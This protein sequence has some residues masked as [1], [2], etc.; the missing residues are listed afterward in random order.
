M[1]HLL[2]CLCIVLGVIVAGNAAAIS[3]SPPRV[4][5]QDIPKD[6]SV[7]RSVQLAGIAPGSNVQ[8]SKTGNGAEWV[9]LGFGESFTFPDATEVSFP[10]IITVPEKAPNGEY[11]ARIH[12]VADAPQEAK[13]PNSAAVSSGVFVDVL[14]TVSGNEVKQYSIT[15]VHIPKI[16]AGS[17]LP[18]IISIQNHGNVLAKPVKVDL[19]IKDKKKEQVLFSESTSTLDPVEPFFTGESVATFNI[20]LPAELYFADVHVHKDSAII[21]EENIPFE[22]LIP[23]SLASAGE[24]VSLDVHGNVT[25]IA[26]IEA[27]FRNTGDVGFYATLEG[28]LYREGS[29]VDTFTSDQVFFEEKTLNNFVFFYDVPQEGSYTVNAHAAF[30]NKKSNT[31][32]TTFQ[33]GSQQKTLPDTTLILTAVIMVLVVY[34]LFIRFRKK[35]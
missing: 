23:G 3:V 24:L 22:V 33:V 10:F 9:L 28:E 31:R 12:I 18:I 21:R 34:I 17:P 25:K 14:F 29:L 5:L 13:Q 16:E 11:E 27:A 4:Q 2:A 15:R 6:F 26:K 32:E 8:T 20:N 1:K 35:S 30:L 19:T 7:E